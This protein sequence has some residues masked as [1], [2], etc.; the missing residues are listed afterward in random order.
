MLLFFFFFLGVKGWSRPQGRLRSLNHELFR[1]KFLFPISRLT[2]MTWPTLEEVFLFFYSF[3]FFFLKKRSLSCG[4]NPLLSIEPFNSPPLANTAAAT[5]RTSIQA[6]FNVQDLITQPPISR[7][8]SQTSFTHY[9]WILLSCT[10][11]L[12]PSFFPPFQTQPIISIPIIFCWSL[13]GE[14]HVP[15]TPLSPHY[16]LLVSI[17]GEFIINPSSTSFSSNYIGP[18]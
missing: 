13:S 4:F 14:V 9:T 11:P 7:T 16:I 5:P 17:L 3:L 12:P 18:L 10:F 6:A 1:N 15:S 8:F 2:N